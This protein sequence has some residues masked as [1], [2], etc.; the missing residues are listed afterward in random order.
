MLTPAE[1]NDLSIFKT[2]LGREYLWLK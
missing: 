1:N 2:S